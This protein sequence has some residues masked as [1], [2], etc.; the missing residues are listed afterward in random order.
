MEERER[1]EGGSEEG[2]SGEV[3]YTENHQEGHR[4]VQYTQL[5]SQG[6]G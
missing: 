3:E 1:W 5:N 6:K 4:N 2:S